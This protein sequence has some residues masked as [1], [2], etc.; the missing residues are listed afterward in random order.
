MKTKASILTRWLALL[1]AAALCLPILAGCN[2]DEPEETSESESASESESNSESASES[3]STSESE[4]SSEKPKTEYAD[5]TLYVKSVGGLPLKNVTV[6]IYADETLSRL[7]EFG[8]T[9]K[10]GKVTF[11]DLEVSSTYHVKVAA[12]TGY[13]AAAKYLLLGNETTVSLTSAVTEGEHPD[14]IDSVYRIGDV[15]RDFTM[16]DTNGDTYTLSEL[17]AKET[18]K[19]KNGV[20]LNFWYTTC[21]YCIQEFPGMNAAYKALAEQYGVEVLAIN[22][23]ASDNAAE[24]KDF[25]DNLWTKPSAQG[26][27]NGSEPLEFPMLKDSLYYLFYSFGTSGYP[28]T[29]MIDRYGVITMIHAGA[30][31]ESKFEAIFAT[32]GNPG[33]TQKLYSNIDDL[34]PPQKPG[35]L[36]LTM[37]DN[38]TLVDAFVTK[39]NGKAPTVTFYPERDSEAAEYAFPFE[40][41]VKNGVSAIRSTNAERDATFA[42]LY[43]DVTLNAGDVLAFDY[44]LSSEEIN[45]EFLVFVDSKNVYTVSGIS[46]GF[47]TCVAFVAER[48]DT[49]TLAFCYLKSESIDAGEDCVYLSNFRKISLTELNAATKPVYIHRYAADVFNQTTAGYEIYAD[50]ILHTDGFYYVDKNGNDTVDATDPMLL[51]DLL[52]ATHFS[53]QSIYELAYNGALVK[54]NYNYYSDLLPY[55]SY[56]ANSNIY[57][58]CSVNE[59]LKDLLVIVTEIRGTDVGNPNEWLQMC[60]YYDAYAT[61]SRLDDPIKGLAT[62]TAY[63]ATEGMNEVSYNRPIIPRGLLSRFTPERSGVYRIKS[64]ATIQGEA[65]PCEGWIFSED[66]WKNTGDPYALL[67]Y[68]YCERLNEDTSNVS[69]VYY[70]EAGVDYYINIAYWDM[71]QYGTIPFTITYLGENYDY[72]RTAAEGVFTTEDDSLDVDHLILKGATALLHTDGY[73]YAD[74]NKNGV[75][76]AGES[77]IYVDFSLPNQLF[78]GSLTEIV[79]AGMFN[80]E[81]SDFDK[82]VLSVLA[83]FSNDKNACYN[84]Y[85]DLYDTMVAEEFMTAAQRNER[86]AEIDE[87]FEGIYHGLSVG[88]SDPDKTAVIK[89]YLESAYG[90]TKTGNEITFNLTLAASQLAAD[91]H[92]EACATAEELVGCV[93]VDETLADLLQMLVD[94]YVFADV[95]DSWRAL[96]YYYEHNPGET[97][98]AE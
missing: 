72:F 10:D 87:I 5:Y 81:K 84:Y 42:M 66:G 48:T 13:T 76:D 6:R 14:G 7:I 70:M 90:Y 63:I 22:D 82:E 86:L 9:D 37:P 92:K 39:E 35:E 60:V 45:D 96:C 40:V 46:D 2:P 98:A 78:E 74:R 8:T 44:L 54:N 32:L 33:Y 65:A 47:E 58:V 26:G 77:R 29:V 80:F 88:E 94:T 20:I 12:P 52:G 31:A 69:M 17:L 85:A 23:Y 83:E 18:G 15:M 71:Y 28:T 36:G 51:C 21:T 95:E 11:E 25:K 4:S 91:E 41:T 97:I 30:I 61:D 75:V 55:I 56:S 62:H 79:Y 43:A 57:G 24:V 50:V 68:D 34:V 49:Y 38:D 89:S 59:E 53:S 67:V 73:Y 64:S 19:G 1:L 27:Y 16:T 3:E 93:A